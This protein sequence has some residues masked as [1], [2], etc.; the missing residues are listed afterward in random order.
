MERK[1]E[2]RRA[3]VVRKRYTRKSAKEKKRERV[4]EREKG[5]TNVSST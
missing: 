3:N 5:T 2:R 4:N 1:R